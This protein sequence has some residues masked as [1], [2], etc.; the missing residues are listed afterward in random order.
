MHGPRREFSAGMQG[1]EGGWLM[2]RPGPASER[3]DC[4]DRCTPIF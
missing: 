3:E 2:N 1:C 4:A